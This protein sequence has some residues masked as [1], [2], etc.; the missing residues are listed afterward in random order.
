MKKDNVIVVFY[1]QDIQLPQDTYDTY[2]I[3]I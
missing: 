3:Y 2:D 1:Q